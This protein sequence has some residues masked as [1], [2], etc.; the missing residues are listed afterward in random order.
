MGVCVSE[1]PTREAVAA[2]Q[3]AI[4]G[5][6]PLQRAGLKRLLIDLHTVGIIDEA[7]LREAF[8]LYPELRGS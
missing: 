4:H 6:T 2:M 3:A 1:Y 7:G 8:R 5:L